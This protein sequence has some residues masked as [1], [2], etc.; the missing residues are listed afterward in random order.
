MKKTNRNKAVAVLVSL[1]LFVAVFP[2]P[3]LAGSLPLTQ[4]NCLNDTSLNS[5]WFTGDGKLFASGCINDTQT[6]DF[7]NNCYLIDLNSDKIIQ[8]TSITDF[9]D[10]E[11]IGKRT[12]GEIVCTTMEDSDTYVVVLDASLQ[13]KT[14]F[15][16][17]SYFPY[18]DAAQDCLFS[19]NE[20]KSIFYRV[21]FNGAFSPVLRNVSVEAYDPIRQLIVTED[22]HD[23]LGAGYKFGVYSLVEGAYLFGGFERYHSYSFG[24]DCLIC[25]KYRSLD[26]SDLDDSGLDSISIT[27]YGFDGAPEHRWFFEVSPNV[28]SDAPVMAV[29]RTV[30]PDGDK[31]SDEIFGLDIV[32]LQSGRSV[33]LPETFIT[34]RNYDSAQQCLL[35]HDF[36]R[37]SYCLLDCS[38]LSF[39]D[40]L[41]LQPLPD[42]EL[43]APAVL[44]DYLADVR[45]EADEIEAEFGIEILLGD[46]ILNVVDGWASTQERENRDEE[47]WAIRM[48]LAMIRETFSEHLPADFLDCFRDPYGRLGLRILLG[49]GKRDDDSIGGEEFCS[50]KWYTIVLHTGHPKAEHLMHE[51]WHALEDLITMDHSEAINEDEWEKLNP[52]GFEYDDSARSGWL[53]E[54]QHEMLLSEG[55]IIDGWFVREYS[56]THAKEDRATMLEA[57]YADLLSGYVFCA[58]EY[59]GTMY[60]LIT[61]SPHLRAKLDYLAQAVR[62]YFGYVFWEDDFAIPA[63]T[64]NNGAHNWGEPVY[65]WDGYIQFVTAVRRCTDCGAKQQTG[66]VV[67]FSHEGDC[68]HS[69]TFTYTA[70]FAAPF[71]TQVKTEIKPVQQKHGKLCYEEGIPSSVWNYGC[72]PHYYCGECLQYFADEAGTV[73]LQEED[74][75]IPPIQ[76]GDVD[77]NGKIEPADARLALRIAVKFEPSITLDSVAYEAANVAEMDKGTVDPADAR[78]ILRKAVGF[79]DDEFAK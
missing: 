32:E 73:L 71:E 68:L 14:T 20:K 41:D 22:A 25:E 18:F 34:S 60:D 24:N 74:V 17:D 55:N 21:D 1:L 23:E 28:F 35:I 65:E 13:I 42:T 72:L 5:A 57:L 10:L 9:D 67:R 51:L 64:S 61:V 47:I 53:H 8:Q 77:L 40:A 43:P 56:I 27:V 19:Y 26:N 70:P 33:F 76:L 44:G 37:D 16:I 79:E 46:E 12:N 6:G 66:S 36:E 63:C 48:E 11:C 50:S 38:K 2:F 69:Y 7:V 58:N 49:D 54:G 52:D 62:G 59:T 45:A 75:E 3:T 78:L 39:T 31:S 29:G 4:L 30:H 15:P